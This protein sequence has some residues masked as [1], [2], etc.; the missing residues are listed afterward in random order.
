[1]GNANNL[2][3]GGVLVL[4]GALNGTLSV[5][6]SA[7]T[8]EMATGTINGWQLG[9][10]GLLGAGFG[11]LSGSYGLFGNYLTQNA[12]NNASNL[13][14]AGVN[15]EVQAALFAQNGIMDVNPAALANTL[16]G[17]DAAASQT[18]SNA[19]AQTGAIG[20]ADAIGSPWAQTYAESWLDSA[21][22]P[23]PPN[24]GG[25]GCGN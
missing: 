25:K 7:V 4:N 1:M 2:G 15:A 19:A 9:A 10:S 21:I 18:M 5:A 13:T 23:E 16:N 6:S 24:S 17:I 8:Q 14:T 20:A 11:G 3:W 12:A 22:L